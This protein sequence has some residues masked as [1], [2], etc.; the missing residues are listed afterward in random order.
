MWY[1]I[2]YI[3]F[4][5]KLNSNDNDQ[6]DL[7]ADHPQADKEWTAKYKEVDADKELEQTLK[8]R[9]KGNDM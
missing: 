3:C 4:H 9:L 7:Y 5:H 1:D 8:G 2:S 6:A